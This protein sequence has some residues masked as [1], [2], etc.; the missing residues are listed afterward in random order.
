MRDRSS[1]LAFTAV[2][3]L[4]GF[5]VVTQLRSRA[6]DDGLS[7]L[8]VQ[9]LGELVANLTTRNDQLRD[10]IRVLETQRDSVA[11]AV[12]GGDTSAGQ[13]RADLN[14]IRGWSGALGV[15]GPGVRVV[16]EGS[17]PG[18]GV[19]LLLNELRNAGAEALAV[20][21]IRLVPGVV[22][23]GPE[24]NL[25]A[26]GDPLA[27]PL[28]ILA[29][30]QPETLGGSLTR[31]GGPIARLGSRYPEVVVTV[32]VEDRLDLPPT[33]RDLGPVLGTPR[34]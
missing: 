27:T 3:F 26:G 31:A 17:I 32:N 11:R 8:S 2:V 4:L 25:V 15:A 1:L 9:E 7:G 34:L 10:E 19:E 28:Q 13:I 14:R 5:L 6:A 30:G 33:T 22:V 29:V 23:S 24:G 20:G 21:S 12:E 18:D 16:I